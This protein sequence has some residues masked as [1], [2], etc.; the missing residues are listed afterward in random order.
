M[1]SSGNGVSKVSNIDMSDDIIATSEAMKSLGAVI[2]QDKDVLTI[3]GIKSPK[4]HIKE[5][6][7][8]VIDCNESGSTLRF[9]V[10]IALAFKGVTRFIGRGNLGKD[11]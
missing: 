9:L 11:L 4:N 7:K 1:C 8:E 6:K 2:E 3:T 5:K 10:P